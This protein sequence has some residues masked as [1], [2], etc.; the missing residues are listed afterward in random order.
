VLGMTPSC[1]SPRQIP[2]YFGTELSSP[3]SCSVRAVY[4]Y[5]RLY[6]DQMAPERRFVK[7]DQV[8]KSRSRSTEGGGKT[9]TSPRPQRNEEA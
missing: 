4:D 2:A 7:G 1:A 9:R 5:D 3:S 6:F 8:K